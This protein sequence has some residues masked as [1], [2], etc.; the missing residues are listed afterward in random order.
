MTDAQTGEKVGAGAV[1]GATTGAI[2]GGS[3]G[4]VVANGILPGHGHALCCSS[5]TNCLQ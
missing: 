4:L 1:G 2:V 3:V 5:R